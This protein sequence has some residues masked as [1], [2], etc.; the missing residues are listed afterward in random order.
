MASKLKSKTIRAGAWS[1]L[2]ALSQRGVQFIVGVILARLLLPEQFGLIGMLLVFMAISQTFLDSGF[3]AA[4]IQ[5]QEVSAKDIN[6]IFYFNVFI[7]IL[8]VFCLFILSPLVATFYNQPILSPLLRLI[9]LTIIINSF[10]LVHNVLLIKALNFKTQTKVTLLASTISGIIGISMAYRGYGVWSLAAQQISNSSFRTIL[11]WFFDSWRPAWLF[12]FKSLQEM[13]RFGSNLLVSG[14][15][16]T[17]FDNIYLVVIGKLFP[18]ADLG[19]F[20]RANNLQRLP[21]RTLSSVVARV[22]FPVFS[23]IQNDPERVKRGMQKALTMLAFF[24][25]PMM[26]GL[27]VVAR[28]LVLIL[29]T[30]KWA[31]CIPYLQLLCLVGAMFPLH[32]INLNVLQ[33]LGKSNLFL[34]LEIIKKILIV[35]NI[36]VTYR[37]GIL[38]MISGQIII[39]FLSYYLNAYYNKLLINYSIF[40]QIRD[41]FPYFLATLLM[42]IPVYFMLYLPIRSYLLLLFIQAVTGVLI[43][44]AACYFFKLSAYTAFQQIVAEKLPRVQPLKG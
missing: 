20:T 18:P 29:L 25:F 30:E 16:N 34:R 3:G 21:S 4:L 12:S 9:S 13:F 19:Y 1:F 38:A 11:L 8:V 39:S 41:I 22:T 14:L 31:P 42:A 5:K 36:I 2:E 24:N 43:Y 37:W 32:L 23:T 17:F 10:G 7:G 33:A 15:L 28:P 6:S 44:V 35:F 27:A 26:I 40:E